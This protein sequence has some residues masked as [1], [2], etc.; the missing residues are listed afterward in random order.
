MIDVTPATLLYFWNILLGKLQPFP[1]LIPKYYNIKHKLSDAIS[2]IYWKHVLILTFRL[3]MFFGYVEY[4]FTWNS[5]LDNFVL[6][7]FI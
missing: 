6:V 4:T 5:F 2:D 7:N 3:V 1:P